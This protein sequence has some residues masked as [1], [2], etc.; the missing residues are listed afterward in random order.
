MSK[1]LTIADLA[2]EA[3]VSVSTIDRILSGRGTVKPATIKHVLATA[4][5]IGFHAIG[6]IRHRTGTSLPS[7]T[8]GFLLNSK[9][10]EFYVHLAAQLEMAVSTIPS[11]QGQIVIRYL[12]DLN[13]DDAAQQL[14]LLGARCNAVGCV[15]IDHPRI[16]LAVADLAQK[17]TP[18]I[19]MISDLSAP[20][21]YG[22]VGSN[23]WQLGRTAGWFVS[24][25]CP[26]GGKVALMIGN[27][28]YLSQQTHG[29]GFR[30]FL[31]SEAPHLSLLELP[32]NGES[33][34]LAADIVQSALTQHPDLVAI[35][36]AGGG[37]A[38][39]VKAFQHTQAA[40]GKR[41]PLVI[42]NEW[43]STTRA[44]LADGWIDMI[45]EH[46]VDR[47]ARETV[48]LMAQA[49]SGDSPQAPGRQTIL[50]FQVHVPENC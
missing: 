36:V 40:Q 6:S 33:D 18:V 32:P 27:Q 35:M 42:G 11:I 20:A 7:R 34:A 4:E 45:L 29:A 49:T 17:G 50:P 21:R 12:S 43:T 14:A 23:D 44:A 15:C 3:H 26:Q 31:G 2:R 22:F 47:I 16:A 37:L 8:F 38:G 39:V 48:H 19:P 30:S 13:P 41:R 1:R 28:R 5:R 46:P 9:E 10:R 24:R 25:F